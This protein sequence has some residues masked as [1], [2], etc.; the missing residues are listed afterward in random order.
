MNSGSVEIRSG[1][2]PAGPDT[3]PAD[4]AV[5]AVF[6]LPNPAFGA[7]VNGVAP[8][9]AVAAVVAAATGVAAWFR[10]Y[11]SAANGSTAELDGT[12]GTANADMIIDAANVQQNA[13]VQINSFTYTQQG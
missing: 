12:V 10:M 11:R 9:N 13:H 3:A 4:G 7:A 6:A 8:L 5:L 2:Q 1:T